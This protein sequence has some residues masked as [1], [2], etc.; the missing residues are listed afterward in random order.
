MK[1]LDR[2]N[3]SYVILDISDH[4]TYDNTLEA[5]TTLEL[6]E[7]MDELHLTGGTSFDWKTYEKLRDVLAARYG[8]YP[9]KYIGEDLAP[10]LNE[11]VDKLNEVITAFEAHRHPL[12][13][14]Y[15]EKPIY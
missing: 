8:L 9:S 14:T 3:S 2:F 5:L 11:I 6:V 4:H 15:G 7:K 13:K 12:D 1:K 10:R